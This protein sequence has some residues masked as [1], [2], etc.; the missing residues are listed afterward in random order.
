MTMS[1]VDVRLP[2]HL[3]RQAGRRTVVV[4]ADGQSQVEA[5]QISRSPWA[6]AP[7]VTVVDRSAARL[8][9]D[10][11]ALS[12]VGLVLD[13]RTSSGRRQL[14]AF[15]KGFFHLA[16]RGVWMALREPGLAR[17]SEPLV[18]L[19]RR[20][21]KPG[22]R[23]DMGRPW[24]PFARAIKRAKVAP[25]LVVLVKKQKHVLRLRDDGGAWPCC[26]PASRTSG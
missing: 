18:R 26:R 4:I 5:L 17:G 6:E 3:R 21:R 15:R 9:T 13:V 25:E 8:H 23:R 12:D 14:E 22:V 10:L 19:V 20:L 16:P 2:P 7:V 24:R 11:A 1:D